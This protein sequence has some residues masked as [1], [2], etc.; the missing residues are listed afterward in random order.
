MRSKNTVKPELL[1]PLVI[2][3]YPPQDNTSFCQP[4]G[5]SF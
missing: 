1:R 4:D 5:L 3:D 2:R